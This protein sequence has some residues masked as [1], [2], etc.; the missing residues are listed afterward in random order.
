[1]A[2]LGMKNGIS[3]RR[4]RYVGKE[5][6]RSLK[7]ADRDDADAA[8]VEVQRAIHRLTVGI[9]QVPE[10]VDA[11]GFILSGGTLATKHARPKVGPTLDEVA[12]EFQG[13]LAHL[14]ESNRYTIGVHLRNLA[15]KLGK[16][17]Q[18]PIDRLERRDLEAFLQARLQ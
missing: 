4:F 9:L 17:A 12:K 6:K 3:A 7:T 8:L 1:M 15:K 14:A 10:G 16:K 11:G 18:G 2:N 13:N 5:Y